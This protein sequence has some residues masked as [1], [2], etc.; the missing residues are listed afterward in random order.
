MQ[1][2]TTRLSS[3]YLATVALRHK[4]TIFKRNMD[5]IRSN[6]SRL[7]TF[8]ESHNDRFQWLPPLAGPIAFP[9]WLGKEPVDAFCGD[10]LEKTGVLL[11]PGTLYHGDFPHFRIGF[12][13][14][15]LVDCIEQFET[16]MAG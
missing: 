14:S 6:L 12:G 15:N 10:L 1:K 9:K 2:R 16:Y 7:D 13:R 8:F 3:E 4:D 11:L 5:I